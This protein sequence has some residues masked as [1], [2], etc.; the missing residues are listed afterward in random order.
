MR[1]SQRKGASFFLVSF[2]PTTS[3]VGGVTSRF[4]EVGVMAFE[5]ARDPTASFSWQRV[6]GWVRLSRVVEPASFSERDRDQTVAK[7]QRLVGK[8]HRR[9]TRPRESALLGSA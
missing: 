2:L 3:S 8:L 1:L 4:S 9:K 6:F 7:W 5:S